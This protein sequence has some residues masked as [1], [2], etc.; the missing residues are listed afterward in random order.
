[1]KSLKLST[2]QLIGIAIIGFIAVVALLFV[3][4]HIAKANPSQFVGT[5]QT[6]SA[7][8]TGAFQTPGTATSTLVYDT[9]NQATGNNYTANTVEL[10]WQLSA[11][12]TNTTSNLN[13]EYSN[14][15][16]S[17]GAVLD[18]VASPTSC[19]WYEDTGTNQSGF[20][21]SSTQQRLDTVAQY[22]WKFASSTIAGLPAGVT[23]ARATRALHI[24][25]P[26]R[27]VRAVFTC[28]LGGTNC[29]QW[30]QFTPSK[31]VR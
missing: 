8:S 28:A 11:S 23:N 12:S 15:Y 31:E 6:A 27:Y 21:T 30:A 9:F 2:A 17:N 14:G 22:Q 3:S 5:T 4:V 7:T 29:T 24:M 13:L 18:C 25:A 16:G 26:T 10:L 1:M 19:D 20:A